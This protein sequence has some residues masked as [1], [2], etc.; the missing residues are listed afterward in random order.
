MTKILLYKTAFTPKLET[1]ADKHKRQLEEAEIKYIREFNHKRMNMTQNQ[2]NL[3]ENQRNVKE[4][5]LSL[6]M[7]SS[8][9]SDRDDGSVDVVVAGP[10]VKRNSSSGRNFAASGSSTTIN[11]SSQST[12]SKNIPIDTRPRVF[13]IGTMY[14]KSRKINLAQL[15]I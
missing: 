10:S 12:F 14:G 2:E 9:S 4:E 11:Y 6:K 15:L 5:I 3:S 1:Q 8:R 7:H 13:L